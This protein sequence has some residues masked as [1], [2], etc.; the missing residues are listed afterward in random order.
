ML[1]TTPLNGNNIIS[2]SLWVFGGSWGGVM[3]SFW[4]FLMGRKN[5]LSP[6]FFPGPHTPQDPVL[7]AQCSLSIHYLRVWLSSSNL[8]LA[9][10]TSNPSKSKLA[11][12]KSSKNW[13]SPN[14]FPGPHTPQDPV[15]LAQCSL[16]IHYLRVWVSWSSLTLAF[17]T[18][19]PSKSKLTNLKSSKNW[20]SPNF[21]PG[22]HT[23]QEA[24]LL[25]QS[26]LS[27]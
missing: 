21:F 16:S 17:S 3:G 12:L 2:G 20:L 24:V 9:F 25:A 1:G 23:P 27:I 22:P 26:S 10:S 8:T 11:N 18:S 14:F 7:L 19:D 4:A 13:L 15:L 6:I 5:W